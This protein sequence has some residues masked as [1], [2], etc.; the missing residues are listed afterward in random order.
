MLQV[1]YVSASYIVR[2]LRGR[3]TRAVQASSAACAASERARVLTRIE[4]FSALWCAVS[5]PGDSRVRPR[6]TL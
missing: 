4:W 2:N 6:D 5:S 1:L 3:D